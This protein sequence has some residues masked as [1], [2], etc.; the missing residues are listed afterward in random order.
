MAEITKFRAEEV[1]YHIRHDLRELSSGSSYGNTAVTPSLSGNNYSLLKDRCQTAA[2]ANKYRKE[3]EK[4]CFKY[5]R[6][7]LIHAVEVVVQCP[8]DCPPDQ[9]EQFFQETY[10]YICS[11]AFHEC[12]HSTMKE[13]RCDRKTEG[14]RLK[15]GNEEYSK[16]ELVAEISSAA[17]LHNIGIETPD[18]FQNNCAYIQSWLKALK[19]DKKCIVSAAGKAEKAVEY[20]LGKTEE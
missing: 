11:T 3:I 19:D 15:F 12:A 17:I 16:E 9:H 13:G 10:N 2:E 6:K 5:N 1:V 20:I 8:A 7:N 4:E 18:T 14:K